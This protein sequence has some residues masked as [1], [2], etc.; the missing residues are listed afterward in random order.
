[1]NR[2]KYLFL[3]FLIII[4]SFAS[5]K[6]ILIEICGIDGSGKTTLAR[7]LEK[8]MK[9]E[10]FTAVV[11]KPSHGEDSFYPFLN[12]IRNMSENDQNLQPSIS[13]FIDCYFSL[14]LLTQKERIEN[15]LQKTD[16]V[17]LDRYICSHRACQLAFGKQTDSFDI[18]F[19][20]L[21]Q[22]DFICLLSLPAPIA[23]ERITSRGTARET[24]ENETF[25]TKLQS[26]FFNMDLSSEK[27]T[28][29]YKSGT[30][31][32]EVLVQEVFDA[33]KRR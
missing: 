27:G 12:K 17:I 10:G 31:A 11:L 3:L 5:C 7:G 22:A 24:Y 29:I 15:E 33:M 2:N 25:L 20:Q 8:K 13:H 32:P 26:I 9:E 1:V 6:G 21:P 30:I 28:I 14:Y 16:V 23:I 19:K 18:A 4:P